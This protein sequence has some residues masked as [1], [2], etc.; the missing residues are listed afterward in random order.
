MDFTRKGWLVVGGHKTD[1]PTQFIYSRTV[2]RE[3]IQIAF[4]IAAM[5]G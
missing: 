4:L 5:H 3:S 1:L 2:S